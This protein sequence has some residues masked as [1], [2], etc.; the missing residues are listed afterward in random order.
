MATNNYEHFQ[1]SQ[2]VVL[3]SERTKK[4]LLLKDAAEKSQYVQKY[5]TGCGDTSI[6]PDVKFVSEAF[7]DKLANLFDIPRV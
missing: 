5:G 1:L 3:Y 4:F 6:S 2:K 7:G